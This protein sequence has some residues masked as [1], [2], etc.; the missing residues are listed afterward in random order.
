MDSEQ[1]YEM[2]TEQV[3]LP[4]KDLCLVEQ[5]VKHLKMTEAGEIIASLGS[6]GLGNRSEALVMISP[7]SPNEV[8][9]LTSE[10][11]SR[12]IVDFIVSGH[13]IYFINSYT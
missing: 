5:N 8:L 10:S 3:I 13:G 4:L 6:G 12:N 11:D 2:S 7:S 1:A 9:Q